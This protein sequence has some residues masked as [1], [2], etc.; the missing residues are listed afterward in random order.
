MLSGKSVRRIVLG[1]IFILIGFVCLLTPV[2]PGHITFYA[3]IVFI[4]VG[5][6][7]FVWGDVAGMSA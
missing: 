4:L 7:S 2:T 6:V 3:G 5:I 1:A